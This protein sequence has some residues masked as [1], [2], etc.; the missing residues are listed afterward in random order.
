MD[1]FTKYRAIWVYGISNWKT[2]FYFLKQR[3]HRI[4]FLGGSSKVEGVTVPL[5]PY[6]QILYLKKKV[7]AKYSDSEC[8]RL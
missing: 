4:Q 6:K 2:H 3:G 8:T 1:F 7:F 5:Q